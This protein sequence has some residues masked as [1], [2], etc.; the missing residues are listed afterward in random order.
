LAEVIVEL[1]TI[2]SSDRR[3]NRRNRHAWSIM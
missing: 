1:M 2:E 3:R